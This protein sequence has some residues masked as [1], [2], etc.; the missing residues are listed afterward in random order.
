MTE[1]SMVN[2]STTRFIRRPC[3]PDAYAGPCE[4]RGLWLNISLE[5]DRITQ[6][7]P[8]NYA[9]GMTSGVKYS[10]DLV[11]PTHRTKFFRCSCFFGCV[12]GS[13]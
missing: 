9:A 7:I 6:K 5:E 13:L 2:T 1:N 3:F 12:R 8:L 11:Y 10:K 4:A